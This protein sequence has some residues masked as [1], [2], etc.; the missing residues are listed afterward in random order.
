MHDVGDAY[1]QFQEGSGLLATGNPHA[2]ALPLERARD[3]EPS[4]SSV[5]EALAR[6]YFGAA[7]YE[8][9]A[10]EFAATVELD[11][12][13]DYA[14]YGLGR[15]LARTGDRAGA[16]RHLRLAVAMA[17][18]NDDYRTALAEVDPES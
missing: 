2:A 15:S 16:R 9:A 1:A 18:H 6:A 4:K 5:R 7:R 11:P 10:V 13:N 3:L 17:P 14:H 8:R 12:V